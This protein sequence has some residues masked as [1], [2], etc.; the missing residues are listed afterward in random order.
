MEI[1]KERRFRTFP[2]HDDYEVIL[3]FLTGQNPDISISIG[4]PH[5]DRHIPC[6]TAADGEAVRRGNMGEDNGNEPYKGMKITGRGWDWIDAN[7]DSFVLRRPQRESRNALPTA[8]ITDA[9]IPF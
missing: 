1:A 9:D 7:D 6:T 5:K 2:P 8:E 4:C 3:T